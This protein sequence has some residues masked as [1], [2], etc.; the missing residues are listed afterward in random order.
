MGILILASRS[1]ETAA[2]KEKKKKRLPDLVSVRKLI[3]NLEIGKI[4]Y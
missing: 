3:Y 1:R 4:D 2:K